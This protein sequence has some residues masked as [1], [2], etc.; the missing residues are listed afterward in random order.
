MT[1][2]MK[3]D[4]QSVAEEALITPQMVAAGLDA[5]WALDREHDPD[6][7]IISEVFR[8]MMSAREGRREAS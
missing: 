1:A 7:R 5:Y 4:E 6:E 2:T 8:A 3:Q